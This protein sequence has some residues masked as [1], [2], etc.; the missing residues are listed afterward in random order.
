MYNDRLSL[1]EAQKLIEQR[2]QEAEACSRQ[3]QL[4]YGDSR[5]EY[6]VFLLIV[7]I[8]VILIGLLL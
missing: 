1:E 4:G 5:A 7:L 8:S 6:R 3:K 2:I